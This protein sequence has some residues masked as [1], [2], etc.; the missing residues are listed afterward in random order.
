MSG[1]LKPV[2]QVQ[3]SIVFAV[4]HHTPSLFGPILSLIDLY[5][6]RILGFERGPSV[7][8]S[9]PV[10]AY[11]PSEHT[12]GFD[13]ISA[14]EGFFRGW[15]RKPRS[16]APQHR[17]QPLQH[18][19]IKHLRVGWQ[20]SRQA[21]IRC[22][23]SGVVSV[24]RHDRRRLAPQPRPRPLSRGQQAGTSGIAAVDAN[25]EIVA[26]APH[27]CDVPREQVSE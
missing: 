18:Q 4:I 26:V 14:T 15:A 11:V 16:A 2:G 12:S 21:N 13:A 20:I 8:I 1:I 17:Q 22:A 7:Y 5:D 27:R 9:H 25:A 19:M 3:H 6:F 10:G 23:L 24:C